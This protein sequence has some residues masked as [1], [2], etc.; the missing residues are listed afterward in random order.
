MFECEDLAEYAA[1]RQSYVMHMSDAEAVEHE[2]DIACQATQGIVARARIAA[3]VPAHVEPQH[4]ESSGQQ[5]RHLFCKHSASGCE[6]MRHT[7][8]RLILRPDEVIMDRASFK[9]Q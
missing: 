4:T 9:R 5:R 2:G 3:T 8:N 6:S 7:D 1:H